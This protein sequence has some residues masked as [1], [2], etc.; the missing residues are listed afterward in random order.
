[1]LSSAEFGCVCGHV[2]SISVCYLIVSCVQVY[3]DVERLQGCLGLYSC[4][5]CAHKY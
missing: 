2:I 5:V 1:V 3:T 4:P